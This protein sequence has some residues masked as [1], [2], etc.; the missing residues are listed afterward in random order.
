VDDATHP[1][2]AIVS[3]AMA[4][5][6]WPGL[7]PIGRRFR[8]AVGISPADTFTVIGIASTSKYDS[9]A[10]VPTPLVYVTYSQRPIASFF[11]NALVRTTASPERLIP[12]LRRE[13]HELDSDVEPL[14]VMSMEQYIEPAFLP[15]R[16][17]A[18]LL[19]I[20]GAAALI[21]ALGGLY[22]VMSYAVGQRS[23]EIG[24]R[25]ALGAQVRDAVRMTVRHGLA[26][27]V[28]GVG[29]GQ[30][31]SVATTRALARFLYGVSATDPVTF[32]GAAI[33]LCAVGL[34]ACAVPARRVARVDPIVALRS[35]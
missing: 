20:L 14:R 34:A 19:V 2:V 24:I 28:V 25:L 7:N 35:E 27:V 29:I 8:M 21:L 17:V 5:R 15:V 11:M 1:N 22:A 4:Q 3:D 6:Y 12:A 10:E 30:L 18:T 13:V 26:L 31:L 33:L 9:L 23:R 16:I 32:V